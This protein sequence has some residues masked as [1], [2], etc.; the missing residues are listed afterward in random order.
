WLDMAFST[1]GLAMPGVQIEASSIALLPRM[2]ARTHLLS[3]VSRHT[4][5][6]QR[7]D[8]LKEV[9]L[10]ATTLRRKLGVT[11]RRAGELSPAAQRIVDLLK[12]RGPSILVKQA[13]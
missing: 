5:D 8:R 1:K 12:T 11:V 10:E 3:F 2:I 9:Q 6:F 4:L 7:G 13:A